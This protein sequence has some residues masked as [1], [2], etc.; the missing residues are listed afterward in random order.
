MNQPRSLSR[1]LAS[2]LIATGALAGCRSTHKPP[3]S[4]LLLQNLLQ[5][6]LDAGFTPGREIVVSYVE[7]PPNTTM[8]RHRHPGEE[9][10]YYLEGRVTISIEGEP[11][12]EGT[13]GTVGH[14]PFGKLHTASTGDAGAAAVVFRVHTQG[15]PVRILEDGGAEEQ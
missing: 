7:I 3:P 9:F 4:E 14:I 8:D 10:H 12:F 13:P 1:V 6:P 15:E 11:P 2:G 5:Q